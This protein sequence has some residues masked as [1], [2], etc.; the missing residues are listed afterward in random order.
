MLRSCMTRME[1]VGCV[2][3]EMVFV[4]ADLTV[5]VVASGLFA[6]SV[7]QKSVN[8]VKMLSTFIPVKLR[9][10]FL[11]FAVEKVRKFAR[12]MVLLVLATLPERLV[13]LRQA[14]LRVLRPYRPV[15]VLLLLEVV[16]FL[17][18]ENG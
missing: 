4:A 2:R 10:V 14:L 3:L 11:A 13:P 17:I 1:M 6:A 5:T 15:Q 9:V 12:I 7:L 8:R 16:V 18:I